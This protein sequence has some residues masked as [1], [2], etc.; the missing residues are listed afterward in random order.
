MEA[1]I[2]ICAPVHDAILIEADS[3][4]IDEQVRLM[5]ELMAK[6]S[7]F[8]LAGFELRSYVKIIPRPNAIAIRGKR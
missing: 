5:Q 4:A 7:A 1:G 6:A 8:V 2:K 3:D